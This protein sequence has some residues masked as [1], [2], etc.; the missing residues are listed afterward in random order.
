VVMLSVGGALIAGAALRY[1]TLGGGARE[2]RSAFV[3]GPTSV[4]WCGRF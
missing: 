3:V 2:E 4:A 1:L